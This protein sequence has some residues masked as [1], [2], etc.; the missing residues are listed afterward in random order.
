MKIK[1]I[2]FFS[3]VS[4]LTAIWYFDPFHRQV[5]TVDEL[6]G[7]NYEYAHK[8]YFQSDPDNSTYFNI[9]DPLNEFQGGILPKK[10]IIKDSIIQQHTWTFLNHK[11]TI[12]VTQTDK[13]QGQI[14]DAIRY[15]NGVVF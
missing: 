8:L 10:S 1:I 4:G 9:N 6:I 13:L 11:V 7:R 14:I 5:E 3:I 2:I 15:K 12:W